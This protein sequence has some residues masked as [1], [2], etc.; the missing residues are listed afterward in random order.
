MATCNSFFVIGLGTQDPKTAPVQVKVGAQSIDSPAQGE[1]SVASGVLGKYDVTPSKG[2]NQQAKIGEFKDGVLTI[3]GDYVP[4]RV[5]GLS[6]PNVAAAVGW[7]NS[8]DG[9]YF[10]SRMESVAIIATQACGPDLQNAT[11]D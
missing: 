10:K 9:L 1:M 8:L 11:F 2:D 4:D 3:K 5:G 7:L 6:F